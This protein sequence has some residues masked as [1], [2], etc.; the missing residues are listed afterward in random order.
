MHQPARFAVGAFCLPLPWRRASAAK[1]E[2]VN[3]L[4]KSRLSGFRK[5]FETTILRDFQKCVAVHQ[6]RRERERERETEREG[7]LD[8]NIG[9]KGIIL[10]L[11]SGIVHGAST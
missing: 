1:V 7:V 6:E 3:M 9:S 5:C 11:S 2:T 10:F 8:E 4:N